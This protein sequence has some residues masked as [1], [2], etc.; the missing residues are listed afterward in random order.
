[1]PP[2]INRSVIFV[3]LFFSAGNTG[4]EVPNFFKEASKTK[5]S[6][7]D[8]P[9]NDNLRASIKIVPRS[10]DS[11]C[12]WRSTGIRSFGMEDCLFTDYAQLYTLMG[13]LTKLPIE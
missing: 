6:H 3:L 7:H 4:E 8:V 13:L 5:V 10:K 1:M 11:S 2:V 12:L 9:V